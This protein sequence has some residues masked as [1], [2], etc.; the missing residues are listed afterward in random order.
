[1]VKSIIKFLLFWGAD[2]QWPLSRFKMYE[3]LCGYCALTKRPMKVLSVSGSEILSQVVMQEEQ[4][5]NMTKISY[6]EY[7]ICSLNIEDDSFDLVCCDQVLE[8]VKE[9]QK[10]MDEL[11]RVLKPGGK[12]VVTTCFM[13]MRHG[14]PSDYWRF[15]VEALLYM[16]ENTGFLK[17][18][19]ASSSGCLLHTFLFEMG[20]RKVRVPNNKWHPL[21]FVASMSSNRNY[22]VSWV[23]AEKL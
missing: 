22:V 4:K 5:F 15:T 11:A 10:A 12:M 9:P 19:K 14:A 17:E 16:A 7:D 18:I 23:V 13:N 8:H 3:R 2:R 20:F 21:N 1:M 6:P